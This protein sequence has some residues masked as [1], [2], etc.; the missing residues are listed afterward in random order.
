MPPSLKFSNSV[1]FHTFM[2]PYIFVLY[3]Y[4]KFVQDFQYLKKLLTKTLCDEEFLSYNTFMKNFRK[5]ILIASVISLACAQTYAAS[6]K[7]V[8]PQATM[9]IAKEAE[10]RTAHLKPSSEVVRVGIATTGFKTYD[11]KEISIYGTDEIQ[12]YNGHSLIAKFPANYHIK[13]SYNDGQYRIFDTDGSIIEEIS[14]TPTF[15]CNDG[16]LGVTGLK[17]AG[18]NALYHGALQLTPKNSTLFNLVNLIEVEDYLK[19]VV[20]NEMPVRFG[21]EALKAQSVAARN[22]VLS[23]RTK[24]S[25]NYDVVDS[26]ASQVYYGANTETTLSDE[27][28]LETTGIV[29]LYG[30]DLILAQYSSTA[31]GYTE[32][33]AYAFSD[34]K[35]KAFPSEG[36][37][38]LIAKPDILSQPPLNTEEAAAEFYKSKP[39]SY[40]VRSPYF[41]WTRE[42]SAEEF[43]KAL[44]STLI[45]QSA[46]GFVKPAFVK[47]EKLGEIQ[48][49]DVKKRG[50]SGKIVELDI[51]TA[52]G[53]Y[54][55]FKELVIRRLITKDGK[56]LPSAN[57]VFET[58][59]DDNGKLVSVKAYGGGFG[60]GV[61]MSQ[62]GAGF[63]GSELKLPYEKILQHYYTG[64]TLGTKPVILSADESQQETTQHFYTNDKKTE[65]VVDNKFQVSKLLA[66]INGKKY[67]F[68]LCKGFLG[69]NR[70]CRIDI[71]KHL[72]KG[73][74]TVTFRYPSEEGS[75][76]ALR[77][78][79]EIVKSEGTADIW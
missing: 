45:A 23:P 10:I 13:V 64:I 58:G 68:E 52:N 60:H 44:E 53:T 75:K 19:G 41:R 15:T 31:G 17:R 32:S 74:N 42:W 37:P 65:I 55:I 22:Y 46:T 9:Q 61:G 24:A 36:K 35:T 26:V 38:Y 57:V 7:P 59:Y 69:S 40:D 11:Y 2:L 73:L 66:D 63:M 76:K 62:F 4:S 51:T 28:V 47:G 8:I 6:F 54:K 18:K 29:A 50:E 43:R 12:I 1:L 67:E 49:I 39:D 25:P 27:A 16:L 20:P 34:P 79:V 5:I 21:L 14:G 71:S 77:L 72:K 78:F 3:N 56:A 70:V 30:W 33:Y 48:S